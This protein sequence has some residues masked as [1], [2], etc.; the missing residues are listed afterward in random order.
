MLARAL[1]SILPEMT[2]AEALEA[3]AVHSAAGTLRPG[4]GL[5]HARPFRAPHHTASST[6]LVGGGSPPRPGEL[7]LAHQGVLFL[8]DLPEFSLETLET[9]R[10]PMADGQVTLHRAGERVVL[11]TRFTLVGGMNPCPCGY[12]GDAS[13]LC[14]CPADRLERY[15]GRVAGPMRDQIALHVRLERMT[16]GS[17][18]VGPRSAEVR[19]YVAAA[20]DRAIARQGVLNALHDDKSFGADAVHVLQHGADNLG[21][22]QPARL[23]V[24][25]VAR[26]IADLEGSGLVRAKHAIE[27]LSFAPSAEISLGARPN[28]RRA[29][30][31]HRRTR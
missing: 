27:A 1:L 24:K 9:L 6:G 20:R 26:T 18:S 31:A 8:D 29:I 13:K 19:D 22:S 5:L 28:G 23:Q 16:T 15:L 17:G 25:R 2:R 7:S 3:T 21:L 12:A 10:A 11:P 14:T 4:V 30:G